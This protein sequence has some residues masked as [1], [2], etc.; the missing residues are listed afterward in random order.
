MSA[1]LLVTS[2]PHLR[3]KDTT[4][5]IMLD[6]LIALVPA[7]GAGVWFFGL[8]ALLPILFAVAGSLIGEYATR[9]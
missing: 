1:P 9:V 2:S 5:S 3:A 7:L 6:V 8:A 4:R